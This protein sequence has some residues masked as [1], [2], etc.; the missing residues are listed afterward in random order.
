M[1]RGNRRDRVARYNQTGEEFFASSGTLPRMAYRDFRTM[2]YNRS[3]SAVMPSL[4]ENAERLPTYYLPIS[5]P[6]K[7]AFRRENPRARLASVSFRVS[8][9]PS[10]VRFCVVRKQRREV[11]FAIRKAGY[12]GSAPKRSY[13]RSASSKYGC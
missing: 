9:L 12:S 13:F 3:L 6:A 11:L 10:R 8:E 1:A 4:R 7:R 5:R 2:S